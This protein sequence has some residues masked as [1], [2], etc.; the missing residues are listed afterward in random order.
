LTIFVISY[1]GVFPRTEYSQRIHFH[2]NRY[3]IIYKPRQQKE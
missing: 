3:P 1:L 2:P